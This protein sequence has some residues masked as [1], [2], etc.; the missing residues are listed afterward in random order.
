[1]LY[2]FPVMMMISNGSTALVHA[3]RMNK[4]LQGTPICPSTAY[5]G[6]KTLC[7]HMKWMG[8]ALQA[9][10]EPQPFNHDITTSL[11]LGAQLNFPKI[12]P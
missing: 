12:H 1:M 2:L 10:L 3:K 11:G 6:D 5:Q 8:D 9:G 4:K 7:I